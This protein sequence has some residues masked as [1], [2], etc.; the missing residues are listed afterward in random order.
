MRGGGSEAINK[1]VF[2]MRREGREERT[3]GGGGK[4]AS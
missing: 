1:K 3:P 2:P 4:D